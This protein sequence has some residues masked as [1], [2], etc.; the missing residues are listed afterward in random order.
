MNITIS[1]ISNNRVNFH[2]IKK[3]ET[4]SVEGK[5][6]KVLTHQQLSEKRTKIALGCCLATV[7]AV[8]VIY[9]ATKRKVK[10]DKLQKAAEKARKKQEAIKNM[11]KTAFQL[12]AENK[13]TGEEAAKK[14]RQIMNNSWD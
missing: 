14:F 2:A 5:K 8:D 6:K 13:E 4:N 10:Y 7:L 12:F 1:P 11:P 9:F 3:D